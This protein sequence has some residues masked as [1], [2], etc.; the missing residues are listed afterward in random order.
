M[1]FRD[2]LRPVVVGVDGSESALHA[3]RWATQRALRRGVTLRL[4]H[5]YEVTLSRSR[6]V[7]GSDAVR[8]SMHQQG[9]RWLETAREEAA[10]AAPAVRT[11]LRLVH[12][13][14]VPALVEESAEAAMVVLGTRGLGG[15]IGLLVGSTATRLSCR[16][17]S[18]VIV[19]KPRANGDTRS[20]DGAVVVGVA[21]GNAGAAAVAF[22]FDEAAA[23]GADLVAVHAWMDSLVE[24]ALGAGAGTG[25]D[26][27]SLRRRA[28]AV[29][30]ERLAG[31]QERYPG[32]RV[33]R[34][35]VRDRASRALLRYANSA[36]LVVVGSRGRGGF[37]S[38]VIGSTGQLLLQHA[39]CA[40]AIVR[41][42]ITY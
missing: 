27:E 4:V 9:Q 7:S 40:V 35:V 15:F 32:V 31:W 29:L 25:D 23:R 19:V 12:S 33:K 6:A 36:Q 38:L 42:D 3:T 11:E 37:Q 18:P 16:A 21:G 8:S 2:H 20:E 13:P 39:P 5:A 10:R 26:F 41:S 24:N 30:T 34:E 28:Y 22:A 17:H 14:V 1:T